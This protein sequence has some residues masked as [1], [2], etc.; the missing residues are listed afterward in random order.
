MSLRARRAGSAVAVLICLLAP[1]VAPAQE[2]VLVAQIDEAGEP[3]PFGSLPPIRSKFPGSGSQTNPTPTPT[4]EPTATPTAT[5][6]PEPTPTRTPE[7]TA[8]A[9]PGDIDLVRTGS[10]DPP[11]LAL[12]GLSLLGFG[13]A[14]RLRLALDD[15]RRGLS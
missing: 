11:L 3:Q 6:T 2:P 14:L 1:N 4:E 5:E 13:I 10:D 7:P 8:T 15:A 12:G 9:K